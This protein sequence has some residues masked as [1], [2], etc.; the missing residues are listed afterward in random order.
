MERKHKYRMRDLKY[1][2][3]FVLLPKHVYYPLSKWY[4]SDCLITRKVI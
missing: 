3:D 4:N 2:E 1:N